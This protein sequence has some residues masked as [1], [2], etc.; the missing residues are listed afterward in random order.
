MRYTQKSFTGGEL[1]T[2]LNARND[3]QKYENGLKKLKNGFVH[4][5]GAVSNRAG[6]EFIGET[7]NS[8][9]KS[10]L[11]PFSFNTEQTY[12]IEAGDKYFRFIK[13]GGYIY[14]PDDWG[15]LYNGSYT[16]VGTGTNTDNVTYYEYS[17]DSTS[18]YTS[19]LIANNVIL[20]SD[21]LLT[22]EYGIVETVNTTDL[23]IIVSDSDK[24]ANREQIVEI[25]TP[26]TEDE[27]SILKYAQNADVLTIC[28]PNHPQIELA[29]YSHY[30]W[31][32]TEI[33]FKPK[34]AAPENVTATWTG[35]SSNPRQYKYLV[36]AVSDTDEESN[37][38]EVVTVNGR[39]E[40]YWASGEYMTISWSAVTGAIEYNVYRAVNGVY[41]YLG[42]AEDTSFVD[43]K[44]EPDMSTTAPMEKNPFENGNYPSVVNYFQQRKIYANSKQNP[45][46]LYASQTA[47][48]D[49]F[50]I[51]RPLV[52][53]DA[54]T[55]TLSEREVNE[56]RHIVA[57]NDMIVFT[58]SA[59]WKVNGTDGIFSASPAPAATPQS[60]YG[61]SH[62]MPVVSG[63]MILFVQ[64]GGSVLRDLGY[65]YVSDSYDG[66]ELTIFAN[67]LF[68][69]KQIID[70]AYAKE[71]FRIIWCVLSDGSLCGLTYNR[72]QEING[73]H[74]HETDG[75]FES[76]ACIRE[77]FEDVAYFIVRRTINGQTKRYVE[78]MATRIIYK[79][80]DS[81]FLDS[82]LKY[83]GTPIST[84]H[85]LDHLEGKEVYVNADGG[86]ENHTVESGA[87]TLHKPASIISVGLP[88]EFELETLGIEG[89]N[90]HGIKKTINRVN[91][92][93]NESREDFFIVGTNGVE[94]Q[95]DRSL[96]SDN[97]STLLVTTNVDVTP[98][99]YP[100]EEA[101]IHIKQ[102]YPLPLQI[103]SISAVVNIEDVP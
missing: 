82:S 57:L 69:G 8:S 52:S 42:T 30:E 99:A 21:N 56:I 31:T 19:T 12:I 18:Y 25:E 65:T 85:G 35:S 67:H 53:T 59:E 72:K 49:N 2:P 97:D 73:W 27:L 94:I 55:M 13:D 76:V 43:D 39:Y 29:R 47:T 62:V 38:S 33:D 45:Q 74:R 3:L 58:S 96:D 6:L 80:T 41:G 36:T 9:K 78:R 88:Y 64:A 22:T 63:N 10:R 7:K 84:V 100:T 91:I 5:E 40:S 92:K 95:N 101:T 48:S 4:Q 77:G 60:Y 81:V 71:P 86:V 70:M 23:T 66:D 46:T 26:Y 68:K 32:L 103:L 14:Y 15:V 28:H 20:Y 87:I 54:I 83:E 102:K 89:E 93:I 1:S 17:L 51:S 79:A 34:I 16:Y 61:C 75:L 24:I 50:N 11:I 98:Y 37:R 44:I 90:T